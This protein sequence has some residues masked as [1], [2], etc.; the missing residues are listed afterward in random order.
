MQFFI[1]PVRHRHLDRTVPLTFVRQPRSCLAAL[2]GIPVCRRKHGRPISPLFPDEVDLDAVPRILQP[3]GL[4]HFRLYLAGTGDAGHH[5]LPGMVTAPSLCH[6]RF[7]SARPDGPVGNL[8]HP[9]LSL[10]RRGS[11]CGF[12]YFEICEIGGP[13]LFQAFPSTICF[14]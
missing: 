2:R 6:G 10:G 13:I 12:L 9:R 3:A 8:G 7:P 14:P 4:S 1:R 5:P 11:D